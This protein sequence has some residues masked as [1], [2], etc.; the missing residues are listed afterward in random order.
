MPK[1]LD[2][3]RTGP[4]IGAGRFVT[5]SIAEEIPHRVVKE[6]VCLPINAPT[7]TLCDPAGGDRV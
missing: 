4:V 1:I 6:A 5:T 2:I 7:A 3:V